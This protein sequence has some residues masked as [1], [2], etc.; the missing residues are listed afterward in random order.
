VTKDLDEFVW[1]IDVR[2]ADKPAHLAHLSGPRAVETR[3]VFKEKDY[4]HYSRIIIC[5]AIC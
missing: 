1:E 4:P 3:Y 5:R 2:P